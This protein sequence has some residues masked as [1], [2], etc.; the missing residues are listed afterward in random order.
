M[1]TR[2]K[3]TTIHTDVFLFAHIL[4][5]ATST[6]YLLYNVMGII[7]DHT[8]FDPRYTNTAPI[9]DFPML[10][11]GLYKG[12]ATNKSSLLSLLTSTVHK[13]DPKYELI[14]SS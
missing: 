11:V 6:F 14:G 5:Y 1:Y 13:T 12:A 7:N 8:F 9:S 4:V 3:S 2:L 10:S